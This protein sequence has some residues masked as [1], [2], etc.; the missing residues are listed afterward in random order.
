MALRSQTITF[1]DGSLACLATAGLSQ[2]PFRLAAC[3]RACAARPDPWGLSLWRPQSWL[4]LTVALG[5]GVSGRSGSLGPGCFGPGLAPQAGSLALLVT[6]R[7]LPSPSRRAACERACAARP[8]P[9]ELST[10]ALSKLTPANCALGAGVS[11]SRALMLQTLTHSSSRQPGQI[12]HGSPITI[13]FASCSVRP[14]L[15][16]LPRQPGA[17][18]TGASKAGSCQ[19][20]T[21]SWSLGA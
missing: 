10:Q 1:S 19:Q 12:G 15:C 20:C 21:Q 9:L 2:S 17:L 4:S 11:E 8:D 18:H 13:S 16:C 5:T 7:Q 14:S 6:A 3:G